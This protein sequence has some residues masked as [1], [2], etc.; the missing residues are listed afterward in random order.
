[1]AP[2]QVT[3]WFAGNSLGKQ[4]Q[5][6]L[7]LNGTKQHLALQGP[8]HDVSVDPGPQAFQ[9][10]FAVAIGTRHRHRRP[11]FAGK[12]ARSEL[13]TESIKLL[14]RPWDTVNYALKTGRSR[15]VRRLA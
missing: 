11:P 12:T 9:L 3:R 13:G 6:S 2:H 14:Q 15:E 7:V 5:D 1:M 10:D 4:P 8:I